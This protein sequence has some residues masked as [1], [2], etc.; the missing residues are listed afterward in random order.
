[1]C[2]ACLHTKA[3]QLPYSLSHSQS[4]AP[5]ELIFADVWNLPLIHLA[6]KSIMSALSMIPV[7]SLG[8][9]LFIISLRCLNSSKNFNVLW[10][11]CLTVRLFLCRPI[12]VANM[13]GFTHSSVPLIS[14][15][16]FHA[17]HSPAEWHGRTETSAHCRDGTCF[18]SKC[19]HAP[20]ILGPSVPHCHPS[21][22]SHSH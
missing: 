11:A 1:V 3:H 5:L 10:N 16:I 15:I 9:I 20:Q 18:A 4:T 13:S 2:D 21:Y 14:L 6:I 19:F 12:G 7:V 22:Q 17:P 8:F